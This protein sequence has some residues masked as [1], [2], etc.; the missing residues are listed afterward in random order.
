MPETPE[1]FDNVTIGQ[2]A[3]TGVPLKVYVNGQ[4]LTITDPD[5]VENPLIG[6]ASSLAMKLANPQRGLKDF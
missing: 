2:Y 6:Y 5:D 3:M 1:F 4:Y